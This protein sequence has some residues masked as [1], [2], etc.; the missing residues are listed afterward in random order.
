M[1]APVAPVQIS[2]GMP[3]PSKRTLRLIDTVDG[4]RE[5]YAQQRGLQLK[6]TD[7]APQEGDS[8]RIEYRGERDIGRQYPVKEF[9]VAVTRA[10]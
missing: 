10:A 1:V 2:A 6:L 4:P 5:V 8:I 3:A 9:R 7:Q